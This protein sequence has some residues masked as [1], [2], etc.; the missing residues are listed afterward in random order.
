MLFFVGTATIFRCFFFLK[1]YTRKIFFFLLYSTVI[2]IFFFLRNKSLPK[3]IL[4]NNGNFTRDEEDKFDLSAFSTVTKP[5]THTRHPKTCSCKI[6]THGFFGS[7]AAGR[8]LTTR[9]SQNL[10]SKIQ[11][12]VIITWGLSCASLFFIDTVEIS[13]LWAISGNY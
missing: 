10:F 5:H 7:C 11:Q 13:L 2:T 1:N 9:P 12:R 3:V 6:L 8:V 4:L